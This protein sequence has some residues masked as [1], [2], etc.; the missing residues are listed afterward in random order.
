MKLINDLV[1][2]I[3]TIKSY[4][5]ENHYLRKIKEV[6]GVQ[7]NTVFKHNISASLGFTLF[8]N[9]GLLVVIAIFVPQWARGEYVSS[10]TAFSLLAMI[11][12]LFF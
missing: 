4:A 9:A 8:Q 3:R 1:A 6:R 10:E 5:W 2:G 11:F 12:Y 7:N